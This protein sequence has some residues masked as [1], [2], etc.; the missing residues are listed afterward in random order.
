MKE[1][2]FHTISVYLKVKIH[3]IN[4]SNCTH[5]I[6]KFFV[7]FDTLFLADFCRK[8]QNEAAGLC[9]LI[10]QIVKT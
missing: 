8:F 3:M 6:V 7:E 1:K 5:Y 2:G 9:V 4:T 10:T